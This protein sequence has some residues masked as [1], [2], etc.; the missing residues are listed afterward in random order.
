MKN[1]IVLIPFVDA[2]TNKSYNANDDFSAKEKRFNELVALKLI[3][4]IQKD[5][6][7]DKN[8]SKSNIDS[9]KKINPESND[10]SEGP[11]DKASDTNPESGDKSEGPKDKASDTNPESGD[12]S[13]DP[14]NKKSK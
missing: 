10:K 6:S 3:M 12:K 1:G 11:K 8:A 14:K 2:K 7:S 13:E 4:E 9:S 5:D